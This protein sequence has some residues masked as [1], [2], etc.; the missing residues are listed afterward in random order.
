MFSD[1]Y[2]RFLMGFFGYVVL[3]VLILAIVVMLGLLL[4]CFGFAIYCNVTGSC[5]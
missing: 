2:E 1:W 4:F 5:P 3:P